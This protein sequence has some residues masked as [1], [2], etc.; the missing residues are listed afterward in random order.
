MSAMG[1]LVV[2]D[3]FVTLNEGGLEMLFITVVFT[4]THTPARPRTRKHTIR[5]IAV[6]G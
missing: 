3:G 4:H 1:T 2:A 6:A 5:F